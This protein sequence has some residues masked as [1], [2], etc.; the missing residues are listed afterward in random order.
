VYARI[1]ETIVS[2]GQKE[3]FESLVRFKE[4]QGAEVRRLQ[5]NYRPD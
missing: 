2:R 1:A 3:L 5:D 4:E